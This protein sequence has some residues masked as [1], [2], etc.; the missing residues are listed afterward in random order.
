MAH[1]IIVI[2]TKKIKQV[3][4]RILNCVLILILSIFILSCEKESNFIPVTEIELSKTSLILI[5]DSTATISA[6]LRPLDASSKSIIWESSDVAIANVDQNGMLQGVNPGTITITATNKEGDISAQCEVKVVKWTI[7]N[8]IN[9]LVENKIN[10]MAIDSKGDLWCCGDNISKFNGSVSVMY[11]RNVNP[12]A[13]T[14][15]KSDE[16][17]FG[18]NGYG[19]LKFN[20]IEWEEYDSNNSG[21]TDNSIISVYS[22]S[23]SE[24][25]FSHYS[26][27]TFKGTGVSKFDGFNWK[28][29]NSDNGLI[30]NNVLSIGIDAEDVKWLVTS[31]GISSVKDEKWTSYTSS[32]TSNDLVDFAYLVSIDK[33][34]TKW[35]GTNFG[36]L[37][38]D[39][40]SWISYTSSNSGIIEGEISAIAFDK[41]NNVWV[42][43]V[44]GVSC[45]DGTNWINF[46]YDNHPL[47]D[48]NA[49]VIDSENRKW[50]GTSKGLI[51]LED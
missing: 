34:G 9:G 36:L 27:Q 23:N 28:N 50:I 19:A 22:D 1:E 32:N 18:T 25:W 14:V 7:F 13:I 37:K 47:L 17:W 31:K 15:T 11:K 41:N 16:V 48:V 29:Y 10:H 4:T 6:Q 2:L 44:S 38:F 5:V 30:Y 12:S 40:N 24:I 35:F 33:S 51:L 46:K 21:L 20:G 45:F 8:E 3:Y 39:G 49:L 26:H 42:G 43:T